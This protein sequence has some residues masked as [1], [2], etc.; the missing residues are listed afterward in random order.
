MSIYTKQEVLKIGMLW[1]HRWC[2]R[3]N[4]KYKGSTCNWDGMLWLDTHLCDWSHTYATRDALMQL[5]SH[6]GDVLCDWS[7]E[8]ATGDAICIWRRNC[9]T[10]LVAS[11]LRDMPIKIAYIADH[12]S[13]ISLS[14]LKYYST[15][16]QATRYIVIHTRDSNSQHHQRNSYTISWGWYH[17]T[18]HSR[19]SYTCCIFHWVLHRAR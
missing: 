18:P 4:L 15:F 17:N 8:E 1:H 5:A 11:L 13:L 16:M 10:A 2:T 14:P 3:C 12:L 19:L 7:Q 9:V 6:I